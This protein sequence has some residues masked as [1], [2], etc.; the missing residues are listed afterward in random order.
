MVSS[1]DTRIAVPAVP[2]AARVVE[3]KVYAGFTDDEIVRLT[4]EKKAKVRTDWNFARSWCVNSA[5]TNADA[6]R[7]RKSPSRGAIRACGSFCAT[8]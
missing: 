5:S 8:F 4:G 2:A 7:E 3:L 1:T 6:A